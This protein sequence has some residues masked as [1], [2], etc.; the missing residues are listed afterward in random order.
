MTLRYFRGH[1]ILSAIGKSARVVILLGAALLMVTTISAQSSS[2]EVQPYGTTADG[3]DVDEY[4]LTNANGMEVRIITYGGTITS[5]RAPDREGE[6]A[7]VVLGFDNLADY[8][9]RSP[10]FGNI[11][12]RYANRIANA[13]FT[14]DGTEYELA[15]NSAP[16]SLHGGD[17][18]F[19]NIVWE[20]EAIEGEDEVG[21]SLHYLS[22][23]GDEGYPG[24]L[25]VTVVYTLTN[26]NELRMDYSAN[27]DAP[28][29]VNLTN[30]AY[31]NLEGEGTSDVYD[32]ILWIDADRYT[33]VDETPIP[34]GE[35][36]PVEGTP[37]D[38]R[39]PKPFGSGQRSSHE[40]IVI[41]RGYDH[42][43]VLNHEDLTDNT[44]ML[45]ARISDPDSGRVLEVWT[46]DPGLQ[47]YAGNF[48]DGTLVGPSRHHYR[49]SDGFALETQH[50]PDSP[51]QPD[52]PSTVLRP[53]ET[54]ETAT[55]Y[56]FAVA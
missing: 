8:E 10:Y 7:N 11:T 49:Q 9:T 6:I 46:T 50:F 25:D 19:D 29:V 23:D 35:L 18:G 52:F 47:F 37:F 55:I 3:Q 51:N 14:L 40:Q 33:P 34:T 48:L 45:A 21:V 12:G 56:R 43:F 36:A 15:V 32:H 27:T 2:V 53:G 24:N 5:I 22:P 41:G 17:V 4:I 42:N 54:Y 1:P 38:F 26:D 13:R 28:T 44:M 20:A 16:N 31:F 30:H 39:I